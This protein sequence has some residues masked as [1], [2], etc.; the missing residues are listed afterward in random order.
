MGGENALQSVTHVIIDEIQES[1]RFSEFLLLIMRQMIAKYR[2]FKL[3]L[4]SSNSQITQYYSHYFGDS[5]RV[6][7]QSSAA[8]LQYHYLSDTLRMTAYMSDDMKAFVNAM[9]TKETQRH[10]LNEWVDEIG[11]NQSS[12]YMYESGDRG[13]ESEMSSFAAF[14][15]NGL[16]NTEALV[17]ER[18]ELD[19]KLKIQMDSYLRSAWTQGTDYAFQHLIDLMIVEHISID[20]QHSVSGV[21]ALIAAHNKVNVVESLLRY[22]ADITLCTPTTGMPF[23]GPNTSSTRRCRSSWRRTSSASGM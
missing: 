22:G 1:D 12:D 10:I 18:D 2:N 15:S 6:E 5:H 16:M 20:Y 9:H 8:A 21:T 23:N 13:L 14:G 3:I 19:V 7:I 4:M 17:A 11:V